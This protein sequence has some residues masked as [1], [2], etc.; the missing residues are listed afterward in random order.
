MVEKIAR[1]VN[2]F[3]LHLKENYLLLNLD[4]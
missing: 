1:Q 2:V 3:R 4:Y